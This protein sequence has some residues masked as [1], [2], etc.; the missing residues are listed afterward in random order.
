MRSHASYASLGLSR[1]RV[2]PGIPLSMPLVFD[3]SPGRWVGEN[4][5]ILGRGSKGREVYCSVFGTTTK[6][7]TAHQ[8]I[9]HRQYLFQ[10]RPHSPLPPAVHNLC[11]IF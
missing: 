3:A 5:L 4:S 6:Y 10:L 1:A 7:S 8:P 11:A 2:C 9:S